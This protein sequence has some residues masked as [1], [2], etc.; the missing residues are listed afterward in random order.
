MITIQTVA[1][2]ADSPSGF[3]IHRPSPGVVCG[4]GKAN[5]ADLA[6]A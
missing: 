6:D 1:K 4:G 2:Q 3:C 5:R